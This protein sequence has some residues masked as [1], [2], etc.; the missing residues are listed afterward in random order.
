VWWRRLVFE[1]GNIVVFLWYMLL[2]ELFKSSLFHFLYQFTLNCSFMLNFVYLFYCEISNYLFCDISNM[3]SFFFCDFYF[4][5][6]LRFSEFLLWMIPYLNSDIW[7]FGDIVDRV[8]YL[9]LFYFVHENNLVIIWR[10][11]MI[12]AIKFCVC[13][14]IFWSN[15]NS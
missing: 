9:C 4:N 13:W 5:W 7:I 11:Y 1:C 15:L 12:C 3:V 10:F 6:F 14:F 8:V 2:D